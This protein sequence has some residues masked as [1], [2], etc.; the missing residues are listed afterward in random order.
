[1]TSSSINIKLPDKDRFWF[2]P[3]PVEI[4]FH[5]ELS[6]VNI[7][8]SD[9]DFLQTINSYSYRKGNCLIL[10]NDYDTTGNYL[11][12]TIRSVIE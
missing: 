10:C 3:T 7:L 8:F 1:M 12:A 2:E 5:P 9:S 11:R 6:V 4:E